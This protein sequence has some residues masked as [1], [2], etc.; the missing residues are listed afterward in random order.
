[1]ATPLTYRQWLTYKLTAPSPAQNADEEAGSVLLQAVGD[2]GRLDPGKVASNQSVRSANGN[3]YELGQQSVADLNANYL[4]R[5]NNYVNSPALVADVN[6]ENQGLISPGG[7]GGGGGISDAEAQRIAQRDALRGEISSRGGQIDEVYNRLFGDLEALLKARSGELET[8]YGD[9]LSKASKQFTDALPM[10][11]SSYAALGAGDSTDVTRANKGAEE[12]FD[13]TTKTIGSNK[14]K[15]LASIGQYGKETR[16]KFEADKTAAKRNVSRAG[17]TEDVDALRGLRNDLESNIDAA[18]VT[19]ATLGTEGSARKELS[20]LTQDAGR[21]DEVTNALDTIL[22]SS[23]SGA[24]KQAS[25]KA[26]TDS[27]GLSDDE[28]K[29][30]DQMYGNVY[31]EQQAL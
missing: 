25:V 3:V 28:K 15:D 21:F 27:A 9:Q 4:S 16:A 24:V 26:I 12:G 14:Q 11:E 6:Q 20:G 18:G 10:I 2:D 19:R 1:M 30:V 8:Q 22:K 7:G 31:A 29:K 17:E 13:E 5:Y 23:M